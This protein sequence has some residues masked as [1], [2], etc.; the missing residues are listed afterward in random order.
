MPILQD[1]EIT[2]K[3]INAFFAVYDEL[4]FGFLEKVYCN[5]LAYEFDTRSLAYTREAPVDVF[6]K[7]LKVGHY[8]TD[9]I[10]AERVAVE[11]KASRV[12]DD[13]DRR[14]TLNY[15]RATNH[16]VALL[17]HFGPKAAFQ[18]LYFGNDHKRALILVDPQQKTG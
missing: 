15:L 11:V 6:Y 9:F 3:I 18:R 16:E 14:Q 13:G 8:K 17:L 10:V 2:D 5:A 7:G 12:I 4:G 1:A